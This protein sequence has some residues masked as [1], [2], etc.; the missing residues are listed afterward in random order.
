MGNN[1]RFLL[2]RQHYASAKSRMLLKKKNKEKN[3]LMKFDSEKNINK[4]L[5]ITDLIQ[6]YIKVIHSR[7]NWYTE[8]FI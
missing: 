7:V 5:A 3:M 2:Q 1:V 4:S 8:G 6:Q